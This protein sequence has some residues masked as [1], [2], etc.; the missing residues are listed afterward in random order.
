MLAECLAAV[1]FC[2][3]SSAPFEAGPPAGGSAFGRVAI[4]AIGVNVPILQ[5]TG[6]RTLMRGAGHMRSTW[7][8]G[9]GGTTALFA[10]RVT[11]VLG[12]PHGPFYNLDQLRRG[13]RIIVRTRY[14]RTVYRVLRTRIV[15]E[16]K[17]EARGLPTFRPRW[18]RE[19]ILLAACHPKFSKRQRIVVEAV[20]RA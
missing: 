20:A 14:G 13:Q 4:P 8:P 18:G 9:Q 19:R 5:G 15:S 6:K 17:E 10:H 7:L 2:T 1:V 12:K 11:P 16:A 3:A